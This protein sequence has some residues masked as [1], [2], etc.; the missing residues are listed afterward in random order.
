MFDLR[1]AHWYG[2][3]QIMKMTWPLENWEMK[4]APYV[5]DD[6]FKY[7]NFGGVQER[8]F[9]SSNG[10]AIFLDHVSPLFVGIN[11]SNNRQLTFV[12]KFD[13]P[14]TNPDK[15][16]PYLKYS[17][18][19]DK[20]GLKEV[21]QTTSHLLISKPTN[22]PDELVFKYPI[23]ST[24]A[25]YKKNIN[26]RTVLE[27]ADEI[28][29]RGFKSCQLEIDDD[30]TPHYGDMVFDKNKFPDP[31]WMISKLKEDGFRVTLWVHPFASSVSLAAGEDYWLT[32]YKGGY[33]TWWN[34]IGKCLDV[35]KPDAIHWYRD[36]LQKLMKEVGVVSY[37]FDAG[38]INWLPSGYGSHVNM[39]TPNEYPTRYAELCY[40]VETQIRAQEVRVGVRT[41][42]LPILV[43]MMD[44]QSAW[45]YDNGLKSLIPHALTFGLIGYP[46]VLPDMVGGNAYNGLPDK[47]LYIRWMEA[48]ALMPCVQISIPPWQ[49]DEE[50]VKITKKMLDLH[51]HYSGL[52]IKLAKDAKDYGYPI[53]RPLWWIAPTDEVAQILDSEFLLGDDILVAPILETGMLSRSIYLPKGTWKCHLTN[54]ELEGGK[55]YDNYEVKL[56]ELAYFTRVHS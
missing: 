54:R 39:D 32:S 3:S 4:L 25:V 18:I 5:A 50:V 40:S 17:I 51:E 53:L 36:N 33:T 16:Q 45:G 21:H 12:S 38:E 46:F 49:Y 8:Y 29:K 1:G 37:K 41:Q 44:K 11:E 47:N 9:F 2:G 14:Y 10:V 13:S 34:G 22:I 23:W 20:G 15:K 26:Q 55:W 43:R 35:T 24:W 31:K 30:W 27:F 42:H 6:S 19:Q 56:D 48:N 52:I 28:K 7:G